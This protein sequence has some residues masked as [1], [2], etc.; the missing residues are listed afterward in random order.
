ME[1]RNNK[2]LSIEQ[3]QD[4]YLKPAKTSDSSQTLKGLSFEEILHKLQ[5]LNG[6]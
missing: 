1:I 5:T 4:Q 3:L 2:F 6:I